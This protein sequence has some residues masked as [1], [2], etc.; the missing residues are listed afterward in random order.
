M[1]IAFDYRQRF[2]GD[3][4]LD[5]VC[6][7]RHGHNEGDEPAFTQPILYAAIKDHQPTRDR[8]AEL[9][10]RRK[11][12]TQDQVDVIET[13]TFDRLEK[14]FGAIKERGSDAVPEDG[15]ARLGEVDHDAE[16]EPKTAVD[17]ETLQR[18]TEKLTYDPE[19]IQIHP[20]IKKQIME[21]RHE[22]VFK[23]KEEGGPGIDYGMAENLAYGSLLL[24]GI[25]VRLSGQD[26][27]RG[28][29]AHRHAVLYDVEDGRPYIPLNYLDKSRDEG[30]EEWHPSRFLVYDSLLSEEAVLGFEY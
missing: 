6:Y 14:A 3:V 22:M 20:R 17:L 2:G 5:M 13:Q 7:R 19:V 12:F 23:G 16:E 25:P 21:R 24:E 8:Y 29:F 30:E 18:L 26:C 27:G 11:E 28:T 15:P 10:V 1:R 9:L 4:V